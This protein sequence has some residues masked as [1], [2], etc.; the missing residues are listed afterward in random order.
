M[1][2]ATS[3]CWWST[4]EVIP[5]A[6][7]L[8]FVTEVTRSEVRGTARTLQTALGFLLTLVPIRL[9]PADGVGWRCGF[10]AAGPA[11]GL[12]AM[13]ALRSARALAQ[14]TSD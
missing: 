5:L 2:E 4:P 12:W 1:L 3:A 13:R 7:V 14:P 11:V 10:L 6:M 8:R 9:T